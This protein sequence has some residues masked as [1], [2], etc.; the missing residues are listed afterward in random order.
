ML[1][2]AVAIAWFLLAALPC[3]AGLREDCKWGKPPGVAIAAC[4]QLLAAPTMT[5]A[6]RSETL[7]DRGWAYYTSHNDS[8]AL[9]DYDE[10]IGLSA[11]DW[12]YGVRALVR[13]RLHRSASAM[14]DVARALEADTNAVGILYAIR[15][16]VYAF[17]GRPENALEDIKRAKTRPRGIIGHPELTELLVRHLEAALGESLWSDRG[18]VLETP[19]LEPAPEHPAMSTVVP[20]GPSLFDRVVNGVV[21]V[22]SASGTGTGIAKSEAP[23]LS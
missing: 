16:V 21:L 19:T 7:I 23:F 2:R 14:E 12:K 15:A 8:F 13:A 17:A 5:E 10:A 11:D 1:S 22:T 18:T 6:N 3:E 9:A 20:G 4:T